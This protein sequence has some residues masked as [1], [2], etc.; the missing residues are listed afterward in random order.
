[1]MSYQS[2]SGCCEAQNLLRYHMKRREEVE[3]AVEKK[4]QTNQQTNN[5]QR[6]N[7]QQTPNK[8]HN[9]EQNKQDSED[10]HSADKQRNR[11]GQAVR[12]ASRKRAT[13]ERTQS[14]NAQA[15]EAKQASEAS[16]SNA[17]RS[18]QG[19]T[20]ANTNRAFGTM[21]YSSRAL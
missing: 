11:S 5:K 13:R 4:E 16:K 15:S 17:T 19:K 7:K 6:T 14:T 3:S 10:L 21:R 9:K 20:N 8:R 1:M 18:V 2:R 12:H